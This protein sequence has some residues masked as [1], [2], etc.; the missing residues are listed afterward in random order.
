MQPMWYLQKIKPS[1]GTAKKTGRH[2]VHGLFNL[3]GGMYLV[4]TLLV[5]GD[6]LH[7]HWVGFDAYKCNLYTG[8]GDIVFLDESDFHAQNST[9][10]WSTCSLTDINVIFQLYQLI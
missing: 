4:G 3:P 10:V 7:R 2:T 1:N 9:K 8:D 6:R 5:K